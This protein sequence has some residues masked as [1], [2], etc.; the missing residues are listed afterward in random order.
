MRNFGC[1]I[2]LIAQK[3]GYGFCFGDVIC[4]Q[5]R[6][7]LYRETGKAPTGLTLTIGQP[8]GSDLKIFLAAFPRG[9]SQRSSSEM[10]NLIA[11]GRSEPCIVVTPGLYYVV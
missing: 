11:S 8:V 10:D 6:D 1:T 3:L 2:S 4:H 7:C 5:D 9:F